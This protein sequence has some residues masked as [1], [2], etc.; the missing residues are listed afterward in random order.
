MTIYEGRCI[1]KYEVILMYDVI[2]ANVECLDIEV[3]NQSWAGGTAYSYKMK[4]R[5]C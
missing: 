1:M 4:K 5:P 2:V 3:L